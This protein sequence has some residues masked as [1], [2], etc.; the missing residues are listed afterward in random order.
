MVLSLS[1]MLGAT[2]QPTW[3]PS[4]ESYLKFILPKP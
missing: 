1:R 4:S 3:K 2:N